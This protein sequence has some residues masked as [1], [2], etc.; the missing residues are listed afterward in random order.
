[1][2]HG[3]H[4]KVSPVAG[5]QT[6]IRALDVLSVVR[7]SAAGVSAS[8]VART[9]DLHLSTV[10]RALKALLGSGY[11]A[12]SENTGR[13][14]LG[15]E[16]FLLGR[17]AELDL[18][19]NAVVPVLKE[20]RDQTGESVN[21][22]VREGDHGLVI[23][24]VDSRSPFRFSQ[25]SGSRVPLHCSSTGKVILAFSGDLHANVRSL[26]DLPALTSHTITS[27]TELIANLEEAV[28]RG[29]ATNLDERVDGV[30][31]VSAPVLSPSEHFVAALA[32]QGPT[33][34]FGPRVV[35][36][37]GSAAID[38]AATVAEL[39]PAGYRL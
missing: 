26:P 30:C 36:D 25:P 9:L 2:P 23:L 10:H 33:V 38:A 20:L 34:R 4:D 13:Y 27:S 16:A 14:R 8:E 12:Q 35:S 37:L 29:Y 28:I 24:R 22:V 6:V 15:R 39:L 1:M 19:L 21:L 18:G 31:G 3:S 32:I 17:A 11:V 5:A 7:S